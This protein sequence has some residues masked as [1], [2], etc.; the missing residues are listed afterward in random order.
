MPAKYLMSLDVGGSGG[1]CL[2]LNCQSG[3]TV[4][5]SRRWTHPNAPGL[6]NWAFDGATSIASLCLVAAAYLYF[7]GRESRAVIPDSAAILDE[8]IRLAALER[9]TAESRYWMKRFG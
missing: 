7:A 4:S 9:L 6:G 8:A 1:R 5:A 3:E 2:L